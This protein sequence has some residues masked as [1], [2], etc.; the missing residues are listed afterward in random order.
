MKR[1]LQIWLLLGTLS[2]VAGLSVE[3]VYAVLQT[4]PA[5]L[6]LRIVN[7][8][9]FL[10]YFSA[11]MLDSAFVEWKQKVNIAAAVGVFLI[12]NVGIS[13]LFKFHNTLVDTFFPRTSI[14]GFL[15]MDFGAIV[16]AGLLLPIFGRGLK[17][18]RSRASALSVSSRWK[19]SDKE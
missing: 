17:W 14:S 5:V 7:T 10:M 18:E 15:M 4:D 13:L 3:I 1:S 12:G 9:M 8:V 19:D 11:I 6:D 2:V 16:L